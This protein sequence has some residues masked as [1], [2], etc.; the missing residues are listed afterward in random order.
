MTASTP[1]AATDLIVRVQRLIRAPRE[2]VFDAWLRPE[3]RRRWWVT[4]RPEGLH[5]CEID[6]RVGGRYVMKQIGSCDRDALDPDYE[7][8]MEGEFVELVRPERIVFTWNVN[9]D[10]PVTNN[11]VTI[12]LREVP[13]GTQ[14][15][16]THE[17]CPTPRLRDGTDEGWT[18]LLGHMAALLEAA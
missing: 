6:A 14:V 17:G 9:H 13:G 15:T 16:L 11:R 1:S 8:T 4:G 12:E 7:W 2:R 18:A 5:V 10:P 3:L